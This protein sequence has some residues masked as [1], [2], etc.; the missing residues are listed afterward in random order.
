MPRPDPPGRIR[1]I[2]GEWRRR[3]LTLLPNSVVRPSA[4]RVRETLFNWL[5]PYILGAHCLDLFAGTG[6]LGLEAVS[7]G[8]ERA[9]LVDNNRQVVDR[10]KA[11]VAPLNTDRVDIIEGDARRFLAS[12]PVR[13]F[14][15]VFLDPPFDSD[16]LS[17]VLPQISASFLAPSALVYIEASRTVPA[18]ALPDGWRI[19]RKGETRQT[20]YSLVDTGASAS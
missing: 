11:N 13:R 1:I 6:V 20:Q 15:L 8:A 18:I 16:L 2:G 17:A 4:D 9:V 3:W 12:P 10:L 19:M 5:T 14:D 7:R